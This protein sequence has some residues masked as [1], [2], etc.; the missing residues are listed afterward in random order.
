[1]SQFD[2]QDRPGGYAFE[3]PTKA[4]INSFGA[5]AAIQMLEPI[6]RSWLRSGSTYP[7]P[8]TP[9]I[10]PSVD[11][12]DPVGRA[13]STLVQQGVHVEHL[14]VLGHH[15][16]A[17]T[18]NDLT[19]PAIWTQLGLSDDDSLQIHSQIEAFHAGDQAVW[20]WNL[21]TELG[22]EALALYVPGFHLSRF[23]LTALR[24]MNKR[25]LRIPL[26]PWQEPVNPT[27]DFKLAF[28]NVDQW[29][30]HVDLALG[31]AAKILQYVD[32]V[33][34][35]DELKDYFDWLFN[36][37]RVAKVLPT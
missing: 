12:R 35:Y 33:A 4:E 32:D 7:V 20:L 25:G 34:T 14:V 19:A 31:D 21:V 3:L 36:Q 28:T 5:W 8:V 2:D 29:E 17:G 22:L 10:V 9:V 11:H 23:Y 27:G 6:V 37:S 1:M 13:Y 30:S 26:L 16:E 18:R 24:H 15:K